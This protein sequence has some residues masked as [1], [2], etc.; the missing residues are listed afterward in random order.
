M[1]IVLRNLLTLQPRLG[2]VMEDGAG[3]GGAGG[4]SVF[5]SGD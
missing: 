5:I 4:G 1:K 2:S 3:S